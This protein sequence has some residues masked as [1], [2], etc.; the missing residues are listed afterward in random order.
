MEVLR[1]KRMLKNK[2]NLIYFFFQ[3]RNSAKKELFAKYELKK[4]TIP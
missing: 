1:Y 3:G 4:K 2:K